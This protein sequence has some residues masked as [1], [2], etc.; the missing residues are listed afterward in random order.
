MVDSGL[1]V[2]RDSDSVWT[3]GRGNELGEL[4]GGVG[5]SGGVRV[6]LM[7]LNLPLNIDQLQIPSVLRYIHVREFAFDM[8]FPVRSIFPGST[9]AFV[10]PLSDVIFFIVRVYLQSVPG[11]ARQVIPAALIFHA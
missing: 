4:E 6:P 2:G 10:C 9:H 11:V 7:R 1:A 8:F 3:I 5:A